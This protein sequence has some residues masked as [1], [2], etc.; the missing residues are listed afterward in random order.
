MRDTAEYFKMAYGLWNAFFLKELPQ[1]LDADEI[2]AASRL[3]DKLTEFLLPGRCLKWIEMA[4]IINYAF[5]YVNIY[6]NAVG[7]LDAAYDGISNPLPSFRRFSIARTQFFTDYTYVLSPI[8]PTDPWEEESLSKPEGLD[9]RQ[10]A[11]Q[12]LS[13]GKQWMH[14]FRRPRFRNLSAVNY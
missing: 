5:G 2:I 9:T 14:L 13:L 8:G 10:V 12:L 1:S 4:T 3:C 7:A 6:E 11:A